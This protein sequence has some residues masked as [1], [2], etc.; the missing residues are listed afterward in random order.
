MNLERKIIQV[1][2]SSKKDE[3]YLY[4]PKDEGL[5][6]VPAELMEKFGK[7]TPTMVLLI[8][9]DKKLAR[10]TGEKV[11]TAII[12]NGFYLQLPPVKDEYLLDLY[13]TPTE[14]V[15]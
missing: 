8:D 1:F 14:S 6:R 5:G 15:Y 4:V 11:L 7:A 3:M 10:T 2:R 12:E 9:K 13:K